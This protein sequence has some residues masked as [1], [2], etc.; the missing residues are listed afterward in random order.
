MTVTGCA[1]STA[2]SH[3][4]RWRI[5]TALVA[6]ACLG[7]LAG[8]GGDGDGDDALAAE[9]VTTLVEP[10]TT[11]STSTTSTTTTTTSTT[12]T[13][14]TTTTVLPPRQMTQPMAPPQDEHAAENNPPI[15]RIEIPKIGLDK[16]LE[17]GIRLTTLN[18][19]PGH[20]PG[21][22]MPG[23][24]GNV[25]VA[26]HRTSHNGDFRHIDEL[27]PGDQVVFTT[28]TGT[29]TYLVSG[30]QIVTPDALWI[31]YPSNT[32]TATLFACHPLG[33]TA[34]RIV[35]NLVLSA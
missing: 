14:T 17:E 29:Y 20:W 27:E 31:T 35:V 11:T 24:I 26:G 23:E 8:C 13:S 28:D 10:S 9:I 2:V 18:R 32:Q 22:A 7:A 3:P 25:V 21:S 6:I 15:G 1:T 34:E 12:T 19:G 4:R 16:E 30:T 33:S 5:A